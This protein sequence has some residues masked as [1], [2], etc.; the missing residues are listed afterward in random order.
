MNILP[1]RFFL[2]I[3]NIINNLFCYDCN[4]YRC[5]NYN[6]KENQC[7]YY[8]SDNNINYYDISRNN[9]NN[10]EYCPASLLD[11]ER[12]QT[13]VVKSTI[14]DSSLGYDTAYCTYDR[15]CF[16]NKCNSNKCEG[17]DLNEFCT[18]NNE[19]KIGNFCGGNTCK[20]QLIENKRCNN[21]YECLNNY[22]CFNYSGEQNGVCT[23]YLS[24]K[25][26]TEVG[27]QS[28][29]FCQSYF[30]YNTHCVTPAINE[31]T[32]E[33]N[34]N[35]S[36]CKYT[37]RLFNITQVFTQNCICSTQFPNKKFCPMI[38]DS[39]DYKKLVPELQK[40]IEKESVKKHTDLRNHYSDDLKIK[41][42]KRLDPT[43]RF[44][45]KCYL[46]FFSSSGYLNLISLLKY[47]LLLYLVI[48]D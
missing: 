35:Q 40:W 47:V 31:I 2:L 20:N 9:C 29:L 18:N 34:Y 6:L 45:D 42:M 19:C 28:A 4:I 7:L 21:D 33:C 46:D 11:K 30:I 38:T 39:D 3:S 27:S 36:N 25:D 5:S 14:I 15:N 17:K 22:G 12:N 43:L 13:C 8:H 48:I 24:L 23:P 37:Y 41:L 26:E 1:K 32:D 44:A 16:S 10:D